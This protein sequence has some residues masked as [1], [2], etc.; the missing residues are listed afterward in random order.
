MVIEI[1]DQYIVKNGRPNCII[2]GGCKGVDKMAE[3]YARENGINVEV[4]YPDNS[5]GT[6]YKFIA[7]DKLIAKE[8]THMIAFPS[9]C[10][11]GTQHTINFAK[12]MNKDVEI[13]WID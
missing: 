10:G 5:I 4:Y 9:R 6:N 11:K 1:I 2:S 7:R 3:R 12:E 8:C 13:H